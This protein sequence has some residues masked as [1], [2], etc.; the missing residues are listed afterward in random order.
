MPPRT[1]GRDRKEVERGERKWEK[2]A[3]PGWEGV[4]PQTHTVA[5]QSLPL[6]VE[7]S[8][9]AFCGKQEEDNLGQYGS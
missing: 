8:P 3:G 5:L 7:T 2:G 4:A 6:K 9:E 1:W